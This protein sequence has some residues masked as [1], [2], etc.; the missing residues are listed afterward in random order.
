MRTSV[1]VKMKKRIARNILSQVLE[2]LDFMK[3]TRSTKSLAL[4]I[5][6]KI[7]TGIVIS[8]TMNVQWYGINIRYF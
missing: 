3:N 1:R 7:P 5:S 8:E 4:I 2:T 6:W